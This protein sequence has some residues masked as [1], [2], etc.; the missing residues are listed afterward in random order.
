[1]TS[2]PKNN[3]AYIAPEITGLSS[4]FVYNE[5]LSLEKQ[6]FEI[7]PISVHKPKTISKQKKLIELDK[8]TYYLYESSLMNLIGNNIYMI[9]SHPINYLKTFYTAIKDYLKIG[10]IRR[11]GLGL[12][13]RFFV[14]SSVSKPLLKSKCSLL[15]S[16]FA[17]ISTDIAM[18]A[19]GISG[20]PF[21]FTSHANDLFE[22]GW[23]LK[24]KM[25]RAQFGITISKYNSN[26]LNKF[27]TDTNKIKVV[28]CGVE[29]NLAQKNRKENNRSFVIGSLGR[30]VEK[31]G[32]DILISA[33]GQLDR[34]GYK[35]NLEIAGAGPLMQN[36]KELA[37]KEGI[38]SK[39]Q[40]KGAISHEKVY[41]WLNKLDIFVLACKTDKNG[42]QD[43]IPVVLMEAMS[44]STPV[45]STSISAIPELIEDN[46]SGLLAEPGDVETLAGKLEIMICDKSKR[47][48]FV[49][50]GLAYIKEEFDLDLN[51][52]R[53]KI[54]FQEMINARKKNSNHISR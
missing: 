9:F 49:K 27:C 44:A 45:I 53:L 1:M 43:G 28:R 35:F 29:S 51:T 8:R 14:A 38:D 17:H 13:F 10:I 25:E 34:K 32:F 41:N 40:F 15:H 54:I 36:L 50:N 16:H 42:D 20:I 33:L 39:V 11:A 46:V 37:L 22:R 6:G 4:T 48:K 47:R 3:I 2:H 12:I 7:L 30:L 5:I 23:L 21:S 19:S 26:F 18:Y 24:E 31:K 52:N